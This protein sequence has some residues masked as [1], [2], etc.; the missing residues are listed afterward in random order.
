M[1]IWKAVELLVELYYENKENGMIRDPVAYTLYQV[2][3]M[4]EF[5]EKER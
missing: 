3:K 5:G 4:A 1:S 2:W